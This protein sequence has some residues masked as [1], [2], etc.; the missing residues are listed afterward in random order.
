MEAEA[1]TSTE[2][3]GNWKTVYAVAGR[4]PAP[5]VGRP[6]PGQRRGHQP[7]RSTIR[8]CEHRFRAGISSGVWLGAPGW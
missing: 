2:R 3:N 7:R 5:C 4:R 1:L 6:R 8:A